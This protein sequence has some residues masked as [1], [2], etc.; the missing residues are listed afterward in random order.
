MSNKKKFT[1]FVAK[2]MAIA[3]FVT[4]TFGLTS[5]ESSDNQSTSVSSAVTAYAATDTST[6]DKV[7]LKA[8]PELAENAEPIST[9]SNG[10]GTYT[11]TY[12][13]SNDVVSFYGSWHT[14][15]DSSS[16][17]YTLVKSGTGSGFGWAMWSYL[18]LARMDSNGNKYVI[19]L[20]AGNYVL[21]R[22]LYLF[23]NTTL[24]VTGSTITSGDSV[25]KMVETGFASGVYKNEEFNATKF[26]EMTDYTG[27]QYKSIGD[28]KN[29]TIIGGTWDRAESTK[30]NPLFQ[31]AYVKNLTLSGVT[32][33]NSYKNHLMEMAACDTVNI[34]G[35][36]FTSMRC[37][38]DSSSD[39]AREALQIDVTSSTFGAYNTGGTASYTWGCYNVDISGCTFSNVVRGVGSHTYLSGSKAHSNINIHDNNFE[40]IKIAAYHEN[41][42]IYAYYWVNSSIYNNYINNVGVTGIVVYGTCTG[43]QIF[44][45]TIKNTGNCGISIRGGTVG[46]IYSNKI[47][48]A[49]EEGIYVTSA[50]T[51]K[52]YGNTVKKSDKSG[53]YVTNSS[54][55]S[56]YS[57]TVKKPGKHGIWVAG[58]SVTGKITSNT[59]TTA[60]G[61]GIYI[62][63]STVTKV[64]SNKIK[65]AAS[66]GIFVTNNSTAKAISSNTI[67]GK[68]KTKIGISVKKSTVT[69]ILSNTLSKCTKYGVKI[70]S[71]STVTKFGKSTYKKNANKYLVKNSTIKKYV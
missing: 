52:I 8:A 10:D 65:S 28:L 24:D 27:T 17:T 7:L 5:F 43:T 29:I 42:A 15:Y 32:I 58:K 6:S 18:N 61:H 19:K 21:N 26:A 33:K 59:I 54:V 1:K 66:Y 3:L 40:N 48:S 22:T 68:N 49:G 14:K 16:K 2:L 20:Q 35:C 25:S 67:M 57:N 11:Y 45:N 31:L 37:T 62:S 53:I 9:V 60:G 38:T 36:T 4:G 69:N 56:I 39:Y 23:S 41:D 47:S 30:S 63:K 70:Y 50:T 44:G 46:N 71:K 55:K 13:V 34:T 64:K 51:G 12:Y